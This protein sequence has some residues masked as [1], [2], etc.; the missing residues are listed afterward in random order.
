M[1]RCPISREHCIQKHAKLF[2]REAIAEDYEFLAF[3]RSAPY[4]QWSHMRQRSR[5]LQP[6]TSDTLLKRRYPH[7]SIWCE[8]KAPGNKPDD[9]QKRFGKRMQELGDEWFWADSVTAYWTGLAGK[10]VQF[11]PNAPFL[12][13]HHDASVQGEI[14]A[15]EL[16]AGKLPKRMTRKRTARASPS[17]TKRWAR[18]QASLV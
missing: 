11:R 14:E 15:E 16:K 12:A 9:N 17:D 7:R 8:F 5:G 3:D 2:V 10:G 1:P 6:G 4:G 13:A 18:I